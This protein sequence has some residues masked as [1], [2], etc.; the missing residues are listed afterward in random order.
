M[1]GL[2]FVCKEIFIQTSDLDYSAGTHT[3]TELDH[4]LG[5]ACSINQDH[6]LL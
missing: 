6:S 5:E 4:Q 3:D 1:R 2:P